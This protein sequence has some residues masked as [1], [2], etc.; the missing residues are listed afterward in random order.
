M[1][2]NEFLSDWQIV[3]AFLISL[4]WLYIKFIKP[5]RDRIAVL[6]KEVVRLETERGKEVTDL[7]HADE[8]FKTKVRSE[9]DVL[10][11]SL[12]RGNER[13]ESL[14]AKLEEIHKELQQMNVAFAKSIF[15]GVGESPIGVS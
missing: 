8:L 12:D 4:S 11:N 2:L 15:R 13:F 3:S 6:E 14:E 1:D 9:I 7:Q 5:D 10:K